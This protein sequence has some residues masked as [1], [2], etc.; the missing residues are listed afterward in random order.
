MI[1]SSVHL[2]AKKNTL[3]ELLQDGLRMM[4]GWLM[5]FIDVHCYQGNCHTSMKTLDRF[6]RL[7]MSGT[8]TT[9]VD[10]TSATRPFKS[11]C[12]TSSKQFNNV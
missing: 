1:C 11:K 9:L 3:R 5:L 8:K 10:L 4:F 7:L 2:T 6:V 12:K